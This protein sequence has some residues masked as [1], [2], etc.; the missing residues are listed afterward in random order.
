MRIL[1]SDT[2][3]IALYSGRFRGL[4]FLVLAG[5]LNFL[6][7]ACSIN[8][9]VDLTTITAGNSPVVLDVPFFAQTEYQCGPAALATVLVAAGVDT[10]PEQLTPQVYLPERQGS[11]QLE[12]LAATRRAGRIPYVIQHDLNALFTEVESGRPVLVLQNLK[13]RHFPQWHYA[14]LT[15]FD[16]TEEQVFL[17]TGV[18]EQQAMDVRKFA[19]LW[20]WAGNWA[21]V[22][23]QPGDVPTAAQPAAWFE[24]VANFEPVAGTEAAAVAW[25]AA[26]LKWPDESQ[27][28][29]AL[30][31]QAY[32]AGELDQAVILYRQGLQIEAGNIALANNLASVLGEMGCPR[33]AEKL[34]LPVAEGLNQNSGWYEIVQKTLTELSEQS[35]VANPGCMAGRNTA[36]VQN[37][38]TTLLS[39][40]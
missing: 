1:Q 28:Y 8:P 11:L 24:A 9:K 39:R 34:L 25:R 15:G 14:V 40:N 30:G 3:L 35:E 10:S 20:D 26:L 31:N 32:S 33:Q 13:T 12:L 36:S 22:A 16:V 18:S 38:S 21:L 6:L 5:T 29:L 2:P 7:A 19:R 17:N 23:M 4:I 37:L 27:P